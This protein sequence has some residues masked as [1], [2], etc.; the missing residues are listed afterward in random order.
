M[1]R[2]FNIIFKGENNDIIR[3]INLTNSL[4]LRAHILRLIGIILTFARLDWIGINFLKDSLKI[5][6]GLNNKVGL[7]KDYNG[8][9]TVY[10]D[11]GE[12]EQARIHLEKG[13]NISESINYKRLMA[14]VGNLDQSKFQMAELM[15]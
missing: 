6:T 9:G 1:L 10:M 11:I 14:S 5:D 8:L 7:A 15:Q 2:R 13:L 3:S 4:T 12:F